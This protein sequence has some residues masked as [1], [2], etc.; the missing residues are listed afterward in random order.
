M[1][2]KSYPAQSQ[3]KLNNLGGQYYQ[4]ILI[5]FLF[6]SS[7]IYSNG[8]PYPLK[9]NHCFTP[10]GY[11]GLEIAGK[12]KRISYQ[13]ENS[14]SLSIADHISVKDNILVSQLI[15]ISPKF[16]SKVIFLEIDATYIF[17]IIKF[18]KMKRPAP[19]QEG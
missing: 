13:H 1:D 5:Y 17:L 19:A 15:L 10:R 4:Q 16:W 11:M 18:Q 6:Q 9:N 14:N 2:D 3:V 8:Q 7:I 12:L